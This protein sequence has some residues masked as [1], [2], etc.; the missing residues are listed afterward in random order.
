MVILQLKQILKTLRGVHSVSF[1]LL[2]TTNDNSHQYHCG[3][4]KNCFSHDH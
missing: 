1:F 2:T 4:E 3:N